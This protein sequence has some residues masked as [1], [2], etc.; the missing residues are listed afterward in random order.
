MGVFAPGGRGVGAGVLVPIGPVL[1]SRGWASSSA[2]RSSSAEPVLEHGG[3]LPQP[4][5]RTVSSRV[6]AQSS[7]VELYAAGVRSTAAAGRVGPVQVEVVGLAERLDAERASDGGADV[8]LGVEV[9]AS[10]VAD[11]LGFQRVLFR[12]TPTVDGRGGS[13]AAARSLVGGSS[14]VVRVWVD[15]GGFV[16]EF[17]ADWAGRLQLVAVDDCVVARR[18][19]CAAPVVVPSA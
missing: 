9:L 19:R 1:D 16:D 5:V 2:A 10:E 4:R 17:G 11:G 14:G 15:Y 3:V 12:L 6:E 7:L 13:G 18:D 8:V